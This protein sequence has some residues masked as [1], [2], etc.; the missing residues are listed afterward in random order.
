MKER[1]VYCLFEIQEEDNYN[2]A[3]R[4]LYGIFYKRERA[5]K[6]KIEREK[7]C[8]ENKYIIR[9]EIIK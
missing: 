3:V 5:E 6:E 4:V 7:D 1:I 2:G 9:T 8:P